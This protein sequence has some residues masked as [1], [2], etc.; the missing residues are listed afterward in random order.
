VKLDGTDVAGSLTSEDL[1]AIRRQLSDGQSL[2]RESVDRLRQSQEENEIVTRRRDELEARVAALET[3]YEELLGQCGYRSHSLCLIV[4]NIR[5]NDQRRR[6][7]RCRYG[8]VHGGAQGLLGF[9]VVP[10]Y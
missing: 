2:V 9:Y 7:E 1:T 6:N 10:S 4:D 3:E 5:K 8:R